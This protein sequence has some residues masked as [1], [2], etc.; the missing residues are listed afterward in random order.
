MF[1]RVEFDHRI[2]AR[3]NIQFLDHLPEQP[4]VVSVI[5]DNDLVRAIRKFHR[6]FVGEYGFDFFL[7]L[8]ARDVL[9]RKDSDQHTNCSANFYSF[10]AAIRG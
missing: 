2:A 10:E 1:Q 4:N 5:G 7:Q 6:P 9:K 3:G 8:T